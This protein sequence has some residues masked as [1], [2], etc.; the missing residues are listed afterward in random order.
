MNIRPVSLIDAAQVAEIY[1][2][3]VQ[4]THH[5]FETEP[6]S[7]EEMEQRIIKVTKDYP[8]LIAEDDGEIFGYAYATQFKL[9]QAYAFSAEVSIYVRNAAKQKGIGTQLYMQ[10]F[11]ELAETDIHAIVAGISLPNEP[12]IKFHEKLGFSK[13][14]H[15]REVGYKLGRWVDVGYWEF[16]NLK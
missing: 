5:T 7:G 2:Y 14:A 6:L 13:V 15:F 3:Y 1:N 8:F 9:R 10:L 16:I 4:N 12:S 11:D